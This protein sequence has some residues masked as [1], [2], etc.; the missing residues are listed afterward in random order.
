MGCQPDVQQTPPFLDAVY[1]PDHHPNSAFF[2]AVKNGVQP[3]HWDFGPMPALP[4][5]D[6]DDT[7]A[8]V[9]YIRQE[10]RRAGITE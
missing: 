6:D 4:H 10:Q 2:S 7:E 5:L 1:A 9:A 3:H 8:I